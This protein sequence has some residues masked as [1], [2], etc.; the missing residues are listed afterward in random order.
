MERVAIDLGERIEDPGPPAEGGGTAVRIPAASLPEFA[1]VVDFAAAGS[2]A[3]GE[4]RCADCGYGAVVQRVLPPCPMCQGTVW[5]LREPLA[6]RF[7][8]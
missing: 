6:A 4:F 5:E 1:D 7:G 8:Y 2:D 3:A